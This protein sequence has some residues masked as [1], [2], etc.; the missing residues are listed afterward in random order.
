MKSKIG[1]RKFPSPVVQLIETTYFR[2]CEELGVEP[3]TGNDST[4]QR[5][6][7]IAIELCEYK[8]VNLD[9]VELSRSYRN[10]NE[11]IKNG[12]EGP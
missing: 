1:N 3:R 2:L 11:R 9:D 5:G 7:I 8:G 10:M 12:Q 4:L 6:K